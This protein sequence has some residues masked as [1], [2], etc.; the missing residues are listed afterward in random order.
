MIAITIIS[1]ALLK[2]TILFVRE[3]KRELDKILKTLK[4]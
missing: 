2:A 4:S 1:A 3:E